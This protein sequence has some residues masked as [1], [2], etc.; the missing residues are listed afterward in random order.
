M[1]GM[2]NASS[3]CKDDNSEMDGR[4]GKCFCRVVKVAIL[5]FKYWH[6]MMRMSK[7]KKRTIM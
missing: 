3:C 4:N 1:E 2:E 5:L 7:S 6:L